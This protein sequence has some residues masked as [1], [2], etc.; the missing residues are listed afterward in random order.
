MRHSPAERRRADRRRD[1]SSVSPE[2]APDGALRLLADQA[3][4]RAAG[5][6]LVP[7]NQVRLLRDAAENYPAWLDGIRA[8]QRVIHFESYIIHDDEV[9]YTFAE[10][11]AAKARE[12]LRVRVLYD[13]IGALGATSWRFWR[14]LAAAGVEVRC[15]NPPRWD[16]PLGWLR[17]DHRKSIVVDGR[18]AFVGGL[19]VGRQWAGDVA[20]GI[21]PWRD[22]GV[23]VRGPAVADI[24]RAFAQVWATAGLPVPESELAQAGGVPRTGDVAVRV[25]A[26]APNTAGLFRLDQLIAAGARETLWL[27]DAY[28]VGLTPYVQALCSAARDGV[29]VRLL[30]P[31]VGDVPVLRPISRAGYRPLLEAGVRVYEWRGTMMHAK[32]AVAD[33]R[34]ARVGSSNLNIASW[35]GNYELDIAV[36]HGGFASEME[37]MYLA[38]LEHAAEIVLSA[39]NRVR[40][41]SELG[42]RPRRPRRR[43][44][45]RQVTRA[46]AGPLAAT[47]S[48]GRAAAG[49]LRIGNTVGAAL[50]DRRILGPAEARVMGAAGM[51]LLV[52]SMLAVWRPG[53]VAFPCAAAGA[54]ISIALLIRALRLRL[55]RARVTTD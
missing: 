27:S 42:A 5:A 51:L 50:A 48:A 52:V 38:D 55:R 10:A 19:C 45:L 8:A 49:A 21:E 23:E 4:S 54:W 39:R 7:G 17:R 3:F 47:G 36:E 29:D 46:L 40:S 13:W 15:F 33:S 30:V 9:G 24:D 31:G 37:A 20:R 32:T 22:T 1:A 53:V 44:P 25:I 14:P 41:R 2:E 6:P 34:W 12:G 11:L 43:R 35:I 16:S 28:F 26:S 18:L